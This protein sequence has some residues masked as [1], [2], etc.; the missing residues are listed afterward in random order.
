MFNN[1]SRKYLLYLSF[2][3]GF[4]GLFAIG[5]GCHNDTG[6]CGTHSGRRVT[7]DGTVRS[8]QF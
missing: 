3:Q 5:Y 6:S 2:Q 1:I 7:H 4:F 8:V